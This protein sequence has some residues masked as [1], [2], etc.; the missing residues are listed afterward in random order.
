MP[1]IAFA[2]NGT[3]PLN[4]TIICNLTIIVRFSVLNKYASLA[5]KI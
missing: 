5:Y 1:Y 3:S 2:Y 4:H